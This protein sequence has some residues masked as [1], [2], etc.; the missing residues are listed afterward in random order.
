MANAKNTAKKPRK[1]KLTRKQ[2]ELEMSSLVSSLRQQVEAGV[3]G[4]AP[5][6]AAS[7]QRR[8]QAFASFRFFCQTYFPHYVKSSPATLH[9]WLFD[10]FQRIVDNGQGDHLAVAAPRGHAK[11]TII[12][13]LGTLWCICTGRKKY[14]IIV[15]DALEQ[16]L[17]MLEAI[18]SELEFNSRLLLDFPEATG[19]GR[20]WQVGVIVTANDIKVEVFGSGK[21]I[22]GRRHGPHRP[23]LVIGDDLENDENVASPAQR[24]KLM[25]WVL[26]SLLSLGA[27]D[28][29]L[30]VVIIGTIL[31]YDSVLARLLKNPLWRSK[32]F[33]AIETW[34]ENMALWDAWA[35]LVLNH[36]I[37]AGDAFYADRRDE[38]NAGAEICWPGGTTLYKLMHKRL[39]DGKEAFDSEMQNNPL[40]GENAPFAGILMFWVS[41]LKSWVM[42]G[43]VDPSLGGASRRADPAAIVVGGYNRETGVLDVVDAPVKKRLPNIIITDVIEMQREYRCFRWFVEDVQFQAFLLSTLVAESAR[44]GVHVPAVGVTPISDKI[45]RIL[46]IQ[47]YVKHGLIRFAPGLHT[48]IEQFEHF[49]LADHDDG[50]DAVE[51][52]W[53]GA[54]KSIAL[55]GGKILTPGSETYE[56]ALADQRHEQSGF[57]RIGRTFDPYAGSRRDWGG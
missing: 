43:A 20:C 2:F 1:Q 54:T 14:P 15:M 21:K 39:R 27:A 56:S 23:D 8:L 24:D 52:L 57:G 46:A 18:K 44:L 19:R 6:S 11:S 51:M 34:P 48:L 3:D 42:F 17:P 26:K 13:Q 38:M 35:E 7:A 9:E 30:D 33:R 55:V 47:P 49:P 36:G 10:E 53:T 41:R 50:P 29:S 32:K 22:R 31:H 25:S 4:F 28:D 16:A 40:S 5:D 12:T 45:L 37:D